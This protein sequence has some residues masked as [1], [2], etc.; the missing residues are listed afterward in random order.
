MSHSLVGVFF[1]FLCVVLAYTGMNILVRQRLTIY[2][3]FKVA[4]VIESIDQM[5]YIYFW[6]KVSG[7]RGFSSCTHNVVD[8]YGFASEQVVSGE[9]DIFERIHPDDMRELQRL[10]QRSHAEGGAFEIEKRIL[11]KSGKYKWTHC[12]AVLLRETE[13]R[14]EWLG[15]L[16]EISDS[17]TVC[18]EIDRERARLAALEDGMSV[19]FETWFNLDEQLRIC[20]SPLS[21][22]SSFLNWI[23]ER[24]DRS[25]L[26]RRVNEVRK[27]LSVQP[28]VMEMALELY[29]TGQARKCKVYI[30]GKGH[31]RLGDPGVVLVG[32]KA[33]R[34]YI[35]RS[36][37]IKIELTGQIE[38]F[39]GFMFGV[40]KDR[41]EFRR[42]WLEEGSLI[43]LMACL[44]ETAVGNLDLLSDGEFTSN[45]GAILNVLKFL[46]LTLCSKRWTG[47]D[48]DFCFAKLIENALLIPS[49]RVR[50]EGLYLIAVA[51][52]N[53]EVSS[54]TGRF[55]FDTCAIALAQ[56]RSLLAEV[57]IARGCHVP[58]EG[59]TWFAKAAE[60]LL[61]REDHDVYLLAVALHNLAL[62]SGTWKDIDEADRQLA[63]LVEYYGE[64]IAFDE[65]ILKRLMR[66]C[67]YV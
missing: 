12:R 56:D 58:A 60:L 2:G 34:K 66:S 15:I 38:D 49:T 20:N 62:S 18:D 16:D 44:R 50:T 7:K 52:A 10:S 24:N 4:D 65:R 48:R 3:D 31:S 57:H 45:F 27:S 39:V 11:G 51:A 53:C 23:P 5:I 46:T 41:V 17:K 9:V 63:D 61:L 30:V 37:L 42:L 6:D 13:T 26:T 28:L 40:L 55:V 43:D 29:G 19:A 54:N 22:L 14:Q 47:V 36:E 32:I 64:A 35:K 67:A 59:S 25:R 1:P 33:K 21:R 8:Y